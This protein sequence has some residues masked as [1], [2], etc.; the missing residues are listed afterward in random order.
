MRHRVVGKKLGRN[1][2]HRVALLKSLSAEL[3]EHGKI[4]TSLAKAKYVRPYVE[5]LITKAKNDTSFHTQKL[6][7]AKLDR[8]EAVRTLFEIAPN[9]KSRKGGYTRIVKTGNRE[10][11]NSERARIELVDYKKKRASKTTKT[12]KVGA[13]KVEEKEVMKEKVK[14]DEQK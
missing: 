14:K 3:I 5:K 6:L 12:K 4:N 11:D 2:A 1:T 9:Y 7:M 10:G 13:K 8:D